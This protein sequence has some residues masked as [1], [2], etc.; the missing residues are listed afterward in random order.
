MDATPGSS[1]ER[2]QWGE[3]LGPIML[4]VF[5]LAFLTTTWRAPRSFGSGYSL[6]VPDARGL[7]TG[8]R[9]LSAS[10]PHANLSGPDSLD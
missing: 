1:V 5:G 2:G 8:Y 4:Q 6:Q 10:I 9:G 3:T 7:R